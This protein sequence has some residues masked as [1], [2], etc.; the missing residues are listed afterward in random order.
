[1]E[2]KG[3]TITGSRDVVGGANTLYDFAQRRLIT[4][5]SVNRRNEHLSKWTGVGDYIRSAGTLLADG[6][7]IFASTYSEGTSMWQVGNDGTITQLWTQKKL[8]NNYLY[9]YYGLA[10]DTVRKKLF[11]SC[12]TT[13]GIAMLDY[14]TPT[15]EAMEGS[16][17][18]LTSA[19][20]LYGNQRG[21]GAAYVDSP[22]VVAGDWLYYGG[23]TDQT[24]VSRWNIDTEVNE[25]I[26]VANGSVNSSHWAFW[27]DEPNDRVFCTS[28]SAG[29]M[30]IVLNASTASPTAVHMKTSISKLGSN[31]AYSQGFWVD[32]QDPNH[33]KIWA[34][35][36]FP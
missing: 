8:L 27:Y 19:D 26:T 4:M 16:L 18:A 28:V 30:R 11:V 9:H 20:G 35:L 34:S 2:S 15:Q 12:Y 33:M 17:R 29:N 32:P 1:M 10:L 7:L 6:D 14:S 5:N 21:V 31:P 3:H 25:E 13:D 24:T 36:C 22:M 23:T